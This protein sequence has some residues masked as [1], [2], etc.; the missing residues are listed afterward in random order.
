MASQTTDEQTRNAL[1]SVN[2]AVD[3]VRQDPS[4]AENIV[5]GLKNQDGFAEI[6]DNMDRMTRNWM[7]GD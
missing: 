1:E 6:W 5:N 7:N 4:N 3:Q 2:N